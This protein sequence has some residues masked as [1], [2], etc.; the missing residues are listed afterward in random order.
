MLV[1]APFLMELVLFRQCMMGLNVN[2]AFCFQASL[3]NNVSLTL[4]LSSPHHPVCVCK[5]YGS[6]HPSSRAAY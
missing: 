4:S 1:T 3:L 2:V 6:N 5:G